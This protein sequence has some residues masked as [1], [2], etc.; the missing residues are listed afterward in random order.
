MSFKDKIQNSKTSN[1]FDKNIV[2]GFEKVLKKHFNDGYNQ[3]LD[4]YE[5]KIKEC[6]SIVGCCDFEDMSIIKEQLKK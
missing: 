6:C 4:D 3:A 2:D 1:M 5:M